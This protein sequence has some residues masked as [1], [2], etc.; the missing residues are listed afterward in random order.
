MTHTGSPPPLLG[1]DYS[2]IGF[3]GNQVWPD[4]TLQPFEKP[5]GINGDLFAVE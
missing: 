4:G 3:T 5:G 1:P 2:N